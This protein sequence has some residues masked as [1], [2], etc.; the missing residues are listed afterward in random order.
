MS[1]FNDEFEDKDDYNKNPARPLSNRRAPQ[2]LLARGS[3]PIRVD[4]QDEDGNWRMRIQMSRNKFGDKEK[5]IFL[6]EYRKHG[7]MMESASA[8]GVTTGTVRK[9][10]KEDEDFAEGV[11]LADEEYRD[12]LI[13]HHQDLV[14]NGTVKEN[15]DRNGGLISK[16]TVYPI[17]LIELELKKHDAGYRDKQELAVSHSGGVLVAPADV[18]SISDWEK[19]FAKPIKDIT[20]KVEDEDEDP[21]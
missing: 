10:M 9:A 17:R 20:P 12:R 11:L 18:G 14:F 2:S 19:K 15:Y 21:F 13:G 1:D 3:V 16:E 6:D 5:G 8:S 4:Y 7:R